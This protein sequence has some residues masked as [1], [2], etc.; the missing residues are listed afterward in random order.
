MR[1]YEE[2]RKEEEER[3]WREAILALSMG[4][5]VWRETGKED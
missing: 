4:P 3:T 2:L 5:Y 1:D